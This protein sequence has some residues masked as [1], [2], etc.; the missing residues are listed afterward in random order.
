VTDAPPPAEHRLVL[1]TR[2]A[3]IG[4]ALLG[5]ASIVFGVLAAVAF[6][7]SP[8]VILACIGLAFGGFTVYGALRLRAGDPRGARFA[9]VLL[10][11]A[12]V[13]AIGNLGYSVVNG[14]RE[15]GE[16]A[17]WSLLATVVIGAVVFALEQ[18]RGSLSR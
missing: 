17:L 14:L 7:N 3:W 4:C 6:D 11:F 1:A 13:I 10:R 5:V 8:D 12:L 16:H 9:T 18:L 15:N 2:V